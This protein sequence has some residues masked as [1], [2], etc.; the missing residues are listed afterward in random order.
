MVGAHR[1]GAP[2]YAEALWLEHGTLNGWS[3][4]DSAHAY[5]GAVWSD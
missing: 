5:A 4:Q 1:N 3:T 2:E